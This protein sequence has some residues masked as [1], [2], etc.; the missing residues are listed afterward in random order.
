MFRTSLVFVVIVAPLYRQPSIKSGALMKLQKSNVFLVASIVRWVG[1]GCDV[2]A[3]RLLRV[4][5]SSSTAAFVR[6][7]TSGSVPYD[8]GL[9]N[10]PPRN[11]SV[12]T[13]SIKMVPKPESSIFIDPSTYPLARKDESIVED[14]HGIK[15]PDPYRWLEDP[16]SPET[17]AYV[18][19]LNAISTPFIAASP[20]R[21]K[22]REKLTKLWDYEKYG[23]TSKRGKYYFY[24]YNTGLQ[25]QSV[26]YKQ[27]DL[28]EKGEVFLDPNKLSD[29]GTTSIRTQCFTRDGTIMAYGL[30]EKGSD[31]MTLKFRTAEGVDLDDV[32]T[33]VKHSGLDWMPDNSGVFYSRYPEHKSAIEGSSTE[34][35]KFHSLYFHRIGTP[36]KDDILVA[37]FREDPEYMC[38]GTVS[39]DGRYLIVDVSRGC[40]P[41]NLLYYYDLT[42]AGNK[43][44]GKLDLKPLFDKFDAKYDFVDSEGDT[45]LILTNHESPM[46]KLIRVKW[47]DAK[48]GPSRWETLIPE[49]EKSKLDW[50]TP[51]I[52]GRLI[53][54]Y[55]EDVKNTLYV[56]CSKT[57]NRLYEIPLGIGSISGFFGKKHLSEI[58]IAFESFLTPT[59]IYYANFGDTKPTCVVEMKELRRV[60]IAG[61]DTSAINVKQVFFPSRDGTK[62]PMY[63]VHKN[64]LK[65][66]G[67]N[68]ALLNGY[69]GFNIADLPYFSV[70]R[71]LFLQYFGG[72]IAC[73]NLRG[74]SE[75]GE[76][77]HEAGMRERKQNVFDD[78][79]ASAEYLIKNNYTSSKKLAIHGGSNGGL[80]VAAC[81]QQ[82]PELY[83]AVVNRVGVMDMLRFHKFTI[84]GAWLPEYGNP[85]VASDFPFIYKYSPL[86]NIRMPADGGQWPSTLLMT[87]DH[88]DRVVPSHSLKYMAR[89][90]EVVREAK[91][92]QR[93]PL[94]IRVE[95]R[96][97]HGSGKP[98][99]KIIAEL[100]DMYSFLQRVLDLK[101]CE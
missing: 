32:V 50:V 99:S 91:D 53:A 38:S 9:S 89:L 64:D 88:D 94:I 93:N 63:I 55:V 97:G 81:S 56:H 7:I 31:W 72:V 78:F 86:H 82:R 51:V 39:E 48:E 23:C 74:G 66:D 65:L 87:A 27:K 30:S 24:Y 83:G 2:E 18:E 12:T 101:W 75:Y 60:Q 57:G 85:D 29:D 15:V 8:R 33:G 70:S 21:E 10:Q 19:K 43:I 71:L 41:V 67:N 13:N 34:K 52:G 62:I 26:L 84:G 68:A 47:T 59:I 35:H 90:Y 96:A 6:L 80:L 16:D 1:W 98:T 54:C 37:D 44:T 22:I 49:V 3:T 73:A 20:V 76:K 69:G 28:N 40:D 45:A 5:R 58:F 92:V 95:V 79:I 100:V 25:N 61:I 46:F 77:W 11:I 17:K 4:R 14:F 36:Q 42:A